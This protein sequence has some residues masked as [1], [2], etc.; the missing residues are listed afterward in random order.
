[1]AALRVGD[2]RMR[3]T[4]VG[5]LILPAEV[6]RVARWVDEAATSGARVVT[7]GQRSGETT[8]VPTVLV[9]APADAKVSREEVFGPVTCVYAF[10]ELAEAIARA[11]S[12]PLSIQ[13]SVSRT[14]C[15]S[16]CARPSA[17]MRRP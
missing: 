6:G 3:E 15:R 8:Y 11:N 4:E 2:P 14:T 9:D 5:S 17:S 10:R 16:R 7:G 13:A 12:L 1:M